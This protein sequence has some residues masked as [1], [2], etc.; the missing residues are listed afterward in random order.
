MLRSIS[1]KKAY[2]FI[3]FAASAF[4]S[5]VFVTMSLYEVTIANLSPLQLVL[6]GTTVELSVF[7]I[8]RANRQTVRFMG[9]GQKS[10]D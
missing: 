7:L 9:G 6:V 10:T 4:L 5:M 8:G 3:E 2:L 1:P